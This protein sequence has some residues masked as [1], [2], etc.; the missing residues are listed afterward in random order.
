MTGVPSETWRLFR[1]EG[2]G[3]FWVS[4]LDPVSLLF[5]VMTKEVASG[6]L[7][8]TLRSNRNAALATWVPRG[9]IL[10]ALGLSIAAAIFSV[11]SDTTAWQ[12]FVVVALLAL[13]SGCC[14]LLV[15][16]LI[17][18]RGRLLSGKRGEPDIVEIRNLHVAFVEAATQRFAARTE[19]LMP[20]EA[21]E[22]LPLTP[23]ST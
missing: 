21:A 6:Y 15:K 16:S 23:G 22:N 18:P 1:F 7:P 14:G 20:A 11:G 8:L 2:G 3:R 13:V 19:R 9:L 10:G 17:C 5:S 12:F 4:V